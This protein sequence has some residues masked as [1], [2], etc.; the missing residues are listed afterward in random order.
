MSTA[1]DQDVDDELV[2]RVLANPQ[3]LDSGADV[4]VDPQDE[5]DAVQTLDVARYRRYI[6][7]RNVQKAREAE[8]QA[9]KEEADAMEEELRDNLAASGMPRIPL[10]GYLAYLQTRTTAS[11]KPEVSQQMYFDALRAVGAAELIQ[12]KVNANTLAAFVREF[13]KEDR[14]IP[15]ELAAVLNI[16]E[17]PRLLV[18]QDA[19]SRSAAARAASGS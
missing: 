6:Q 17:V 16:T 14:P 5:A 3:T 19:G 18:K 2:A 15:E 9:A 10:D 1:T 7:L 4:E 13:I 11:K 12:P 8:A